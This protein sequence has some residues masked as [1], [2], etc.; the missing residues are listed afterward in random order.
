MPPKTRKTPQQ[1]RSRAMVARIVDAGQ[2]VLIAHGYDG[3]STNRIAKAAG[4]SPGS[5]YQYFPDKDAIV[6]AVIDRY[7]REVAS[8]V[9]ASA[10]TNLREPPEIAI[11]TTISAL[12]DALGSHP[13]LLR[14]VIEQ[15]PR[16]SGDNTVFAFEQQVGELAR[17]A[18]TMHQDSLP[19]DVDFESA[20]WLLVR[21][22][23]HLAIRYILDQPPTSR[24]RFLADIT[25]LIVNYFQ[26]LPAK[27]PDQGRSRAKR[28]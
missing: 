9:Y 19:A 6:A 7:N 18:L 8:T 22:V 26:P 10:L 1:E 3:A 16:L 14:A 15:T 28:E 12:L 4:I 2:A 23:E 13:A 20:S 21:A 24:E 5:L 27:T 11:P 17:V 25:R